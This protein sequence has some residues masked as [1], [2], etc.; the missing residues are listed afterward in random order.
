MKTFPTSRFTHIPMDRAGQLKRLKSLLHEKCLLH[1]LHSSKKTCSYLH[2]CGYL[3]V[4]LDDKQYSFGTL[5]CCR[6]YQNWCTTEVHQHGCSILGSVNWCEIIEWFQNN[7]LSR[8]DCMTV[9]AKDRFARVN[10]H[11]LIHPYIFAQLKCSIIRYIG[12][13]LVKTPNSVSSRC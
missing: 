2:L 10:I 11:Y 1:I 5:L 3:H 12:L 13:I 8:Q 6:Q 4:K 7:F 9:Q